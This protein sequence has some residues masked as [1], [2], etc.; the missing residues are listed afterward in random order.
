[1]ISLLNQRWNSKF[2]IILNFLLK[3]IAIIS[4]DLIHKMDG[5]WNIILVSESESCLRITIIELSWRRINLNHVPYL[6]TS[7]SGVAWGEGV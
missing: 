2:I 6:V 5:K 1:M 4:S 7:A 3:E